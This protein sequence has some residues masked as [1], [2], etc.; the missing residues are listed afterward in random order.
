MKPI[1]F[2][3]QIEPQYGFTYPMIREIAQTAESIGF[4]SIWVSDHF[5]MTTDSVYT[6][7]LECWTTLT[8]IARDT[9]SIRLGSMVASQ[10]YRNP[11]LMANMA[12]S[13]DH[14]SNGRLNYGVGAGWKVIEYNAYG[15]T[16]P[17]SMTRIRQLNEAL[18]V[19][20]RLWVEEKASF[21][22]KYYHIKEALC[23]P[24]PVQDPYIPIW[25]GGTGDHTLRVAAVHADAVNF[26]WSL[27][28]KLCKDRLQVLKNHCNK[29]KRDYREIRKSAG[30]MITMALTQEELDSKLEEQ[31]RNKESPYRRYLGRQP[32]N[33][34]GTPGEIIKRINDYRD[35][36]IDHFILRFNFGEEI[37]SMKMFKDEIIPAII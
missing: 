10:S 19:A 4:E 37:D 13:L 31:I 12:A 20:K 14:I 24:H 6:N 25:V 3:I 18:E 29:V 5:F 32:P 2:G 22:G 11:A 15:Y 1:D 17:N 8:A 9:K 27:P 16:F 34:V 33:I 7:C 35:L 28:I 21:N 26:S 30:L 23:Y 36:G